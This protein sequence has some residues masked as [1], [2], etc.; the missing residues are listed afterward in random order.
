MP[1]LRSAD[2]KL[3]LDTADIERLFTVGREIRAQLKPGWGCIGTPCKAGSD[4]RGHDW[5]CLGA[6]TTERAAR[7]ELTRVKKLLD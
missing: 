1:W 5:V 3:V 6:M 2:K 4:A 7:E